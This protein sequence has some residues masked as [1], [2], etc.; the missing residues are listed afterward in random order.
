[1]CTP[2]GCHSQGGYFFLDLLLAS[3][4]LLLIV[5][6]SSSAYKSLARSSEDQQTRTA[7]DA[8]FT[9][10][11]SVARNPLSVRMSVASH[12]DL[13]RCAFAT[14]G[15]SCPGG[16]A[17]PV[18]I[19]GPAQNPV[20][21]TSEQPEFYHP[22]LRSRCAAGNRA[23]TVR[24]TSWITP[25]CAAAS[26]C[27]N[28][29]TFL[30]DFTV[31]DMTLDRN[32]NR[33]AAAPFKSTRTHIRNG[34][35]ISMAP[36]SMTREEILYVNGSKFECIQATRTL[37]SPPGFGL[38]VFQPEG[39]P[40]FSTVD[41]SVDHFWGLRCALPF[42]K[43]SCMSAN[44]ATIPQLTPTLWDFDVMEPT[45]DS[46][47]ADDEERSLGAEITMICCRIVPL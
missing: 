15:S 1:M 16:T 40:Y 44:A 2:R 25:V 6:G 14:S 8:I 36:F 17:I 39:V 18:A 12:P 19:I 22:L 47:G 37:A 20:T 23:C 3:A 38:T 26:P 11:A 10:I 5:A 45:A 34:V 43:M 27:Q 4:I 42:R 31:E 13:Y 46:C 9:D 35:Q 24:A 28:A 7:V 29:H 30:I 21:G 32:G 41:D 33:Q